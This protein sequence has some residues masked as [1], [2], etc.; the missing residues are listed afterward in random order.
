MKKLIVIALILMTSVVFAGRRG[1]GKGQGRGMGMGPGSMNKLSIEERFQKRTERKYA[2]I[3]KRLNK[4][5]ADKL[6][7]ILKKYDSK[8]FKLRKPHMEKAQKLRKSEYAN[9][10]AQI[11]LMEEGLEL[12]SKVLKLKKQEFN[13]LKNSG[14]SNQI[15]AR[16]MKREMHRGMKGHHGMKGKRGKRNGK[17]NRGRHGRGQ[18]GF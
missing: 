11:K 1:G 4:K 2:K 7:A 3:K 13:E 6:I 14:L 8:I 10:K 16:V 18:G 17:G 5:N 9:F 15:L 12:Q